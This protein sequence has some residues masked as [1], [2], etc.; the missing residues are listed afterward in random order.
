MLDLK[1]IEN[2]IS[3]TVV[4]NYLNV[5]F[6]KENLEVA[7]VQAAISQKQIEAAE[8][9]FKAGAIAKVNYLILNLRQQTTFKMLFYKKML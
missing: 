4:N 8:A 5:L 7:K 3:L 9:R 2:D 1:Q 6:A